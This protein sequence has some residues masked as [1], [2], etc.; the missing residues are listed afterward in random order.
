ME[1]RRSL[2][3]KAPDL[4]EGPSGTDLGLI[5]FFFG[6]QFAPQAPGHNRP[7]HG[8]ESLHLPERQD[9]KQAG[10]DGYL[11]S[12]FPAG[13][14]ESEIVPVVEKKLGGDEIRPCIDLGL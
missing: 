11:D 6:F 9:G 3:K 4:L 2:P 1:P 13:G 8:A 14:Y 7:A 5:L 12:R 10:Q